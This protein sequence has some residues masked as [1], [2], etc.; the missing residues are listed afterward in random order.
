MVSECLSDYICSGN[1]IVCLCIFVF[2]RSSYSSSRRSLSASPH[3]RGI[4]EKHLLPKVP[5]SEPRSKTSSSKLSSH[6]HQYPPSSQWYDDE[7]QM[8]SYGSQRSPPRTRKGYPLPSH[9]TTGTSRDYHDYPPAKRRHTDFPEY[10]HRHP[11]SSERY[12]LRSPPPPPPPPAL[13]RKER[14]IRRVRRS[15]LRRSPPPRGSTRAMYNPRPISPRSRYSSH[16]HRPYRR[17]YSPPPPPLH[18]RDIRPRRGI[19]SDRALPRPS[20]RDLQSLCGPP[21]HLHD[22]DR[23]RPR[24]PERRALRPSPRRPPKSLPSSSHRSRRVDLDRR[25]E[26]RFSGYESG[27]RRRRDTSVRDKTE[28]KENEPWYFIYECTLY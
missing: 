3:S 7:H 27:R 4:R 19:V 11:L 16:R 26:D 6:R 24:S 5:H 14:I 23:V 21:I 12:R 17:S 28:R 18:S 25:R 22:R 9:H 1:H 20:S 13:Q 10:Q 8:H 15:P 2:C